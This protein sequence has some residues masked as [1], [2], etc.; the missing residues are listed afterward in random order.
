MRKEIEQLVHRANLEDVFCFTG[1]RQDIPELLSVCDAFVL[2]SRNEG[3]PRALMEAMSMSLPVVATNAGGIP[4][5]VENN[6]SGLIV[7]RQNP[8]ALAE[9]LV[10]IIHD[11]VL[12][13]RLGKAARIRILNHFSLEAMVDRYVEF[14]NSLIG[15]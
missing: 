7:P 8:D 9:G 11:P 6:V 5:V 15:Q 14:Y 2:P 13:R 1:P 3:M 12:R 10:K 4:E